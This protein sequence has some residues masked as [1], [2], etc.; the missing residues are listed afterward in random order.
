MSRSASDAPPG[1]SEE[2]PVLE[3]RSRSS[4]PVSH[5]EESAP[6]VLTSESTPLVDS[7]EVK[8]EDL[9]V[10]PNTARAGIG[11]WMGTLWGRKPRG[12]STPSL[13]SVDG[14]IEA[15]KA[16]ADHDSVRSSDTESIASSST[17][18][19]RKRVRGTTK[20]VFGTLGLSMLNPTMP[21]SIRKQRTNSQAIP[22]E[23]VAALYA[24]SE[25]ASTGQSS[26]EPAPSESLDHTSNAHSL[27]VEPPADP[28]P[29]PKQG[30]S[31]RAIVNA[32]RVMTGDPASV[33]VDQGRDTSP[34]ISKLALELI[35]NARDQRLDIREPAKPKIQRTRSRRNTTLSPVSTELEDTSSP[36]TPNPRSPATVKARELESRSFLSSVD[37]SALASPVF[38]SFLPDQRRHVAAASETARRATGGVTLAPTQPA[39]KP[40]SVALDSIIPANAQPPTH[41]LARTYTPLTARDFHFTLPTSD[42]PSATSLGDEPKEAFTDRFGF[43]YDISLYDFLLLLRAKAVENTAPA[44]LTGIKVAD[45]REDNVW[46]EEDEEEDSARNTVEIIIGHCDCESTDLV[47]TISISTA[48]T[49]LSSHD[50][51]TPDTTSLRSRDASPASGRGRP[52]STTLRANAPKLRSKSSASILSVGSDTPRHVC[53]TTIK[54]LLSELR[55]IHD[56]RQASLRKEWDAFVDQRAKSS[57]KSASGT[58]H[59]PSGTLSGAASILGLRASLDEEELAHTDGLIGFAQLGLSANSNERKEFD[60]LVRAGIPLAYRSKVWFEC[61]GA[62]DMREPGLFADLLSGVD[63]GS[64]VVREIEKDVGRTMPLNVFFGRTGAGVDK[65]RRVLKAYSRSVFCAL[66]CILFPGTDLVFIQTQSRHRI[67]SGYEPRHIHSS[68]GVC[69]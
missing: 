51:P 24:G 31:I 53:A 41:Y 43:I 48:G 16:A 20:S 29:I 30:Y 1:P 46:P 52:R 69:G 10:S 34:L 13:P 8:E 36:T 44:C 9:S 38:G 61:S 2:A 58:A 55:T 60:R 14:A 57:S 39:P 66:T 21:S 54:R 45:R 49:R 42:A 17:N 22:H 64:S 65:L 5:R 4:T 59:R 35:R 25:S 28:E 67:L 47:D 50:A 3:H 56:R 18:P 26:P 33:L 23:V 32:T 19:E 63:E 27:P 40:G 15:S 11:E 62:L 12:R 68:A 7:P 37:F 6:R